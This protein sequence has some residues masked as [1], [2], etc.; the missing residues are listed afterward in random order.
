[1][2]RIVYKPHCGKCGFPIDTS[3]EEIAY[4]DAYEE[5]KGFKTMPKAYTS[6]YPGKC[7]HCGEAFDC[8]EITPP[9]KLPDIYI[10]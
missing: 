9:K 7:P 8:I 10:Y 1:M 6:V 2:T 4:Q 5:C 3:K